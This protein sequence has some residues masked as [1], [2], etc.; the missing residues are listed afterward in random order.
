M[1][2]RHI[3][4]IFDLSFNSDVE[5]ENINLI[6][7]TDTD[8][9]KKEGKSLYINLNKL[10]QDELS[11]IQE[12]LQHEFEDEERVLREDEEF[13]SVAME[14][15]YTEDLKEIL[16]YFDTF[17]IDRYLNIIDVGLHLR[18][19]IEQRDLDKEDIQK[20]KRNIGRRFGPEAIYLTSLT[21]TGYFDPNGGLRDLIVDMELNSQY[22]KYD[23]QDELEGLVENKLLCVFVQSD[24]DVD[25]VTQEV[26]GR[27]ARYQRIDPIHDWLDIRG[28]GGNCEEI[29]EGVRSNLNNEFVGLDSQTWHERGQKVLRIHPQTIPPIE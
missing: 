29:I 9:F 24:D 4:R 13:E 7:K 16:E 8:K 12:L 5:V 14:R 19:L 25:E 21:S 26:R 10:D 17:L 23:F 1:V 18:A 28:I 20:K 27:I 15:G 22:N 6:D 11:G 2:L 3:E